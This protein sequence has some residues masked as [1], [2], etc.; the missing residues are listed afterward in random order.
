MNWALG[1]KSLGYRLIWLEGVEPD[2][3]AKELTQHVLTLKS[4]L[5]VYGLADDVAL[6]QLDG[7]SLPLDKCANCLGVD[8]AAEVS[9]LLLN[10]CYK[11]PVSVVKKF[12]RTALLDIDPGLL[13]M[14]LA[15]KDIQI[16]PH[17]FYFTI[18]ETV[19]GPDALFPDCGIDW[20]Y[21]PPCVSLDW[22]PI[23]K[24]YQ[25]ASFTTITHWTMNE[26]MED[27][28]EV[29][30][31]DKRTAYQPFLELPSYSPVSLELAIS[32]GKWDQEE[33]LVL[34]SYG[35]HVCDSHAVASTP[36]QYQQYIQQSLGE[37]SCVKPSCIRLQNA[38]ISDRSL[39]YL[40]SGKPVVVQHTGKSKFLPDAA[41]LLRFHDL[42]GAVECIKQVNRDYYNHCA[43]ARALAEEYFDA[44]KVAAQLL[45]KVM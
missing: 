15:K 23:A 3:T 27:N 8:E 4:N 5:D 40:A 29:Y 18:G 41:G 39:C 45:E 20:Q 44:N 11:M 28:G 19:G 38:W 24:P 32:L 42:Q 35:W 33:R 2:T 37:F 12:Q 17:D 22:W 13:Q 30:T 43:L 16:A 14:W 34:Q 31:N 21:T 6:W 1:F 10:Q 7:N 25:D 36:G 9:D 26:F